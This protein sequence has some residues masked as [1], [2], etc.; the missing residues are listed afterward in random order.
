MGEAGKGEG[1]VVGA[2]LGLEWPLGQEA[3]YLLQGQLRLGG[4]EVQSEQPPLAGAGPVDGRPAAPPGRSCRCRDDARLL[5]SPLLINAAHL[6]IRR[7]VTFILAEPGRAVRNKT[8]KFVSGLPLTEGPTLYR[9]RRSRD[10]HLMGVC[11]LSESF[12]TRAAYP[13]CSRPGP[14]LSR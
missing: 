7:M 14:S 10:L 9:S 5:D 8:S 2:L 6:E 12:P 1:V 4:A 3:E 13:T 11:L